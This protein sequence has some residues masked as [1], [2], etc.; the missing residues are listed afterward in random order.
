MASSNR[1][2]TKNAQIIED[3]IGDILEVDLAQD[4]IIDLPH[5]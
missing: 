2:N 5:F 4:R 3:F 1:L